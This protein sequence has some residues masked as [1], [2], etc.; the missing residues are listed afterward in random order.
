MTDYYGNQASEDLDL[1]RKASRY[2]APHTKRCSLT[3]SI[4]A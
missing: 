3:E 4:G 2:R 1:N